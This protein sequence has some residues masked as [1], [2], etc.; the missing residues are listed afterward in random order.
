M[1][2]IELK[3]SEKFNFKYLNINFRVSHFSSFENIFILYD[4]SDLIVCKAN[5]SHPM[6]TPIGSI[7]ATIKDVAKRKRN[8]RNTVGT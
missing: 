1:S 3:M 4:S 6:S 8:C 7:R 2:L 5:S